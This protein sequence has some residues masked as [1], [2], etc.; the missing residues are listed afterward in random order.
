MA[1]S[2]VRQFCSHIQKHVSS[3]LTL[4]TC[5]WC[6]SLS[7]TQAVV[8]VGHPLVAQ[9]V[10]KSTEKQPG[11]DHFKAFC[12]NGSFTAEV[13]MKFMLGRCCNLSHTKLIG[14]RGPHG[15]PNGRA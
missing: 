3:F 4:G 10:L 5:M 15:V 14:D 13:G 7:G 6:P 1:L 9:A 12:G 8:H 2:S 11:Y